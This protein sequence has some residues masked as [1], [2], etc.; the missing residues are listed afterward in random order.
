MTRDIW[1]KVD[2]CTQDIILHHS[3]HALLTT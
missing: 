2:G 1:T 3:W